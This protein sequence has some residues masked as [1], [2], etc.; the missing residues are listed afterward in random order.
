[1]LHIKPI[2]S[3][4]FRSKSGPILLLIQ[5][6]LSVAIVANASF[7]I[8]ERLVLMQ[9]D[10]GIKESEVL[11]FSLFNFDPLIDKTA[12]NKIDQQIL[13]GLPNVI[14]ATSTNMLPLS[15]GGWS[16][17]LNLGPDPDSAKSTPQF[18]M[19][20]GTDHTIETLGIKLIE[21]R[22]FYPHELKDNLDSP[23]R[24][25]IISSVLAKAIWP[26]ESA[27]G[28]VLYEGKDAQITVIGVVEKLQGAWIDSS[29][30]EN[31]VI[32]NVDYGSSSYMVRAKPEFHAELKDTIKKAL[33]AENPN[34]VLDGFKSIE[35]LKDS[36]YRD[37]KLMITVLTMM[38]VLLLLITSLGLT[39]MV[40]FNIQ[41]R[42][43]QIGTRRALGAKKRDIISYFLVE[44]YLICLA[45]GVLGGLLA[46]QLGQQLMKIY[47]LPML[48]LSY[49]LITVA[50]LFIVTTLAV[51]L[52]AR[53]AAN[54]S[55]A[56]ATRSV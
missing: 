29:S 15:G 39:G 5:I 2:L 34:R 48:D 46:I 41:R 20:L 16:S 35:A 7:I 45:G 21:G 36:S 28:K 38:V 6:I 33:L 13:R 18:A 50:G 25:A 17:T 44:N 56:T 54:I 42:T 27:L 47:S 14:D 53:K 49:P 11:T 52:P 37:H 43:K 1:M 8:Q 10:S 22:N 9:R 51:Y 32:Q 55:P 26:D 23:S 19:Y 40:M 30:L 31:S 3:S 4:L 24:L 12:Q